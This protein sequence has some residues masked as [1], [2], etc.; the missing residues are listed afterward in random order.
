M[1]MAMHE[2]AANVNLAALDMFWEGVSSQHPFSIDGVGRA[3]P[4]LRLAEAFL[5]NL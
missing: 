3:E 1:P 5:L 2:V 4:L